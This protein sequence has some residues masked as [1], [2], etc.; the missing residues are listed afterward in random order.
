MSKKTIVLADNSYTIRRIV[1][2][3]FSDEEDIELLTF[4]NGLNL[5]EK[6]LELNPHIVLV[7]IK[8]PEFNGYDLCY[9]VQST[10]ALKHTKV[11]LLKGGFEPI[12]EGL[13]QGLKYE[14]IITKPFDSNALVSNIKKLLETMPAQVAP[15]AEEDVPASFP[16]DEE[17]LPDIGTLPGPDKDLSFS[18]VKEEIESEEIIPEEIPV[19][20]P[21]SDF[22]DEEIL[23]SEEITRAQPD[24]D[25]LA[26]SL[27]EEDNPFVEDISSAS[28]NFNKGSDTDSSTDEDFNIKENIKLQEQELEIDSLTLEEINIK[29]DLERREREKVQNT[30]EKQDSEPDDMVIDDEGE[31]VE[32]DTSEMF[33]EAK[34]EPQDDLFS[35]DKQKTESEQQEFN[36]A[37]EYFSE[38]PTE[39]P[40]F[41]EIKYEQEMESE[42][43]MKMSEPEPPKIEEVPPQE[44]PQ[45]IAEPE[46]SNL[47][48]EYDLPDFNEPSPTQSSSEFDE[49]IPGLDFSQKPEEVEEPKEAPQPEAAPPPPPAP[50]K[51]EMKKEAPEPPPPET[52]ESPETIEIPSPT[53]TP[54]STQTAGITNFSSEEL[55]SKIENKLTHA[56]KEMLWEVVPPL[57]EKIIKEEIDALKKEAES[58]IK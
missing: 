55:L 12:D 17:E 21:P 56:I 33:P 3:S 37:G 19:E 20:Q 49:E 18:D 25:T 32:A 51:A 1:E 54:K 30:Q 53:P 23:P 13:L 31:E 10:D 42:S 35:F 24:K 40:E 29:R 48:N 43:M 28:Q 5:K 7:D 14:D 6:L 41:P 52:P 45:T 44:E 11:F 38:K 57:A 47:E 15:G 9:F 8:L 36:E 26:P 58:S 39:E 27:E 50:P 16:E 46:S 34:L 2:L 4:E 22:S